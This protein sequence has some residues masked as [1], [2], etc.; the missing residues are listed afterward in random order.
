MNPQS[1]RGA[2]GSTWE[3]VG[4][5]LTKCKKKEIVVVHV[6]GEAV[7]VEKVVPSGEI[8]DTSSSADGEFFT[9]REF[10]DITKKLSSK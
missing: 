3:C 4:E 7:V 6:A 1:L 8:D 10:D 2:I 9:A 5:D